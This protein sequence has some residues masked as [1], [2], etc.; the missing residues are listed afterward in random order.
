MF[1]IPITRRRELWCPESSRKSSVG[2]PTENEWREEIKN[3]ARR[4]YILS[5]GE[6]YSSRDRDYSLADTV[7]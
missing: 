5:G 2:M 4:Q 6:T 1:R 7:I 3:H